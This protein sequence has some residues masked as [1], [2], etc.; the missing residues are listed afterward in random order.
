MAHATSNRVRFGFTLTEVLVA[1][2]VLI[3]IMLA[4]SRIFGVTQQVTGVGESNSEVLAQ[5]GA[6]ERQLRRDLQNLSRRGFIVIR[7]VEVPN[8]FRGPGDLIDPNRPP[9]ATI[10]SDQLFFVREG[11]QRIESLSLGAGEKVRP[12]GIATRVYYGHGFALGEA[13]L[14][15]EMDLTPPYAATPVTGWDLVDPGNSNAVR[16]LPPWFAGTTTLGEFLYAANN[17]SDVLTGT[18]NTRQV[19]VPAR[20]PAD[21]P[22]LRQQ[23]VLADDDGPAPPFGLR[24]VSRSRYL[25]GLG[26][27]YGGA[28]TYF[29]P[30]IDDPRG[31]VLQND[32]HV[33]SG[34]Y[35]AAASSIAELQDILLVKDVDNPGDTRWFVNDPD[36]LSQRQ[37]IAQR[38]A[39]PF[40]VD[41][42]NGVEYP[43]AE[44]ISPGRSRIDHNL[45]NS[46]LGFGVSDIRI[47]WTYRDRSGSIFDGAG[48]DDAGVGFPTAQAFAIQD[49]SVRAGQPWFGMT[50]PAR[51]VRPLTDAESTN[52][53]GWVINPQLFDPGND[54]SGPFFRIFR[55]QL[56]EGE[57]GDIDVTGASG[58]RRY[59]AVFGLN[60]RR[61]LERAVSLGTPIPP[62]NDDD[63][64]RIGFT[65]WPDAIRVTLRVHDTEDRVPG[66]REVQFV[67]DLPQTGD[68]R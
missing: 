35:D 31:G 39:F 43:R 33:L 61:A 27:D 57:D 52:D 59:E 67:I 28:F 32:R 22:F 44:R 55:P 20:S 47:E 14:P 62:Q 63:L 4:A 40:D 3:G 8:D 15:A 5:V 60:H 10:R 24:G 46:V 56:I 7:N 37:I 64:D 66:G 23:I 54:G 41:N 9:S 13:A 21:W 48:Q 12:T 53:L 26:N 6:I 65:P 38:L 2:V 19:V 58:L 16:G 49:P 25:D 17:P 1:V 11:V 42:A 36:G 18:G 30:F 29:T 50:D 68:D 45:T 34:R 51:G